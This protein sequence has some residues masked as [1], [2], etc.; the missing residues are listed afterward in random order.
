MNKLLHWW[1]LLVEPSGHGRLM[2]M[3]PKRWQVVYPEAIEFGMKMPG[4]VSIPM[5]YDVACDYAGLFGGTVRKY[6]KPVQGE[7]K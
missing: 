3:Q 4:G 2:A 5:A 6:V 7:S 1:R